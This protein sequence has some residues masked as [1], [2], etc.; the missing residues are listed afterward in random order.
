MYVLLKS[1][2]S[3]LSSLFLP[4]MP[5]PHSDA[6]AASERLRLL[7]QWKAVQVPSHTR[8]ISLAPSVLALLAAAAERNLINLINHA[9]TERERGSPVRTVSVFRSVSVRHSVPFSFAILR[10]PRCAS[11]YRY[12]LGR[13]SPC[14]SQ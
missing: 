12:C 3:P 11:L 4:L 8:Q 9:N 2:H 14:L 7:L 10:L 1:S 5:A 6:A 13:C